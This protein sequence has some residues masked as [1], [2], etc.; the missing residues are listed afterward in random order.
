MK[1]ESSEFEHGR[2]FFKQFGAARV[3]KPSHFEDRD[4]KE[5]ISLRDMSRSTMLSFLFICS[6]L[7]GEA[8]VEL[9]GVSVTC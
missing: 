3:N 5:T 8:A 4:T 2:V 7:Y 1:I 9:I 6:P